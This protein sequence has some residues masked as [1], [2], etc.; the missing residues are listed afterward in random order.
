MRIYISSCDVNVSDFISVSNDQNLYRS[1]ADRNEYYL[2]TVL[3]G[4]TISMYNSDLI[5]KCTIGVVSDKRSSRVK[6][7]RTNRE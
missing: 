5:I 3:F 7:M 4:K 1:H 2:S 6:T